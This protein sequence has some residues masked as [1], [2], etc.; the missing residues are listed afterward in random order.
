MDLGKLFRFE[1]IVVLVVV[2]LEIDLNIVLVKF[3]G[4]VLE[5]SIG[6]VLIIFSID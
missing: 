5:I 4:I 1:S 3:I 2:R 6:S